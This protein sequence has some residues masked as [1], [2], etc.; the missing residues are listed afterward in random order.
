MFMLFT[1]FITTCPCPPIFLQA[2]DITALLL[3]Q[4]QTGP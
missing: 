2:I 4:E 1:T 3:T